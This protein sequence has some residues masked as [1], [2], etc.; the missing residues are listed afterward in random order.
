MLIARVSLTIGVVIIN[1]ITPIYT[2]STR[3]SL[4]IGVVI[5]NSITPIYTCITRV[6]LTIGVVNSITPIYIY[7]GKNVTFD[8]GGRTNLILAV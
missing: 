4:T 1:S 5:I 3:V 2:C 8:L 6:S 7:L